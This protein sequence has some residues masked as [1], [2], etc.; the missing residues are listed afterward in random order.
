MFAGDHDWGGTDMSIEQ[1]K[2]DCPLSASSMLD[3]K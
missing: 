3:Q 2:D 1:N